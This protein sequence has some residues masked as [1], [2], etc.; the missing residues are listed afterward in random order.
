[1][2]ILYI[3]KYTQ[4]FPNKYATNFTSVEEKIEIFE[5]KDRQLFL[6]LREKLKEDK[7]LTTENL[8]VYVTT[9]FDDI[10]DKFEQLN[11]TI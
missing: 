1:M 2:N 3:L 10:T 4:V 9:K 7:H 11:N 5:K 8:R 6:L